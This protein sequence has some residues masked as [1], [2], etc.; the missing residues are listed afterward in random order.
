MP[1]TPACNAPQPKHS[2]EEED[3]E[4][5]EDEGDGDDE[6]ENA[7]VEAWSGDDEDLVDAAGKVSF[8]F[9]LPRIARLD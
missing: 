1:D 9:C 8:L 4:G 2:G 7:K 5:G 3:E 6:G